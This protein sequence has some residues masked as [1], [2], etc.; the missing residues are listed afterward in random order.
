MLR[1]LALPVTLVALLACGGCFFTEGE[2]VRPDLPEPGAEATIAEIDAAAEL[3][4]DADRGDALERIARRYGLACEAQVHLVDTALDELSFD[5]HRRAVLITLIEN[6]SFCRA[7]K[8][9]LLD[10]IDALRFA[11]NQKAV[12]DAIDRRGSLSR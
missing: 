5:D 3:K 11:F 2:H 8:A 6:R 7:A 10:R 1:F 12:L 9:R 4:F